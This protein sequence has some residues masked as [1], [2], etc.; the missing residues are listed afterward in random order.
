LKTTE[1]LMPPNLKQSL[2]HLI[3][4]D[5]SRRQFLSKQELAYKVLDLPE[6]RKSFNDVSIVGCR[7]NLTEQTDDGRTVVFSD[8]TEYSA[9]AE[10][11]RADTKC[12]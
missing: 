11:C 10:R 5:C 7:A 9:Y 6:I 4:A 12:G 8:R 3:F 1:E 2:N